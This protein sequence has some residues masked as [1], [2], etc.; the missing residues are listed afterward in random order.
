[1]ISFFQTFN[2]YILSSHFPVNL[3]ICI[4]IDSIHIMESTSR[5]Q[6]GQ[7]LL[8]RKP[9]LDKLLDSRLQKLDKSVTKASHSAQHKVLLSLATY[10]H[11]RLIT[12]NKLDTSIRIFASDGVRAAKKSNESRRS[13]HRSSSA[14]PKKVSARREPPVLEDV[15]NEDRKSSLDS[16][17]SLHSGTNNKADFV[18]FSESEISFPRRTR[19]LSV[20]LL[21]N[22]IATARRR[23]SA[24]EVI[25]TPAKLQQLPELATGPNLSNESHE[26]DHL[27]PSY[28]VTT[29]FFENDQGSANANDTAR[30]TQDSKAKPTSVSKTGSSSIGTT[31]RLPRLRTESTASMGKYTDLYYVSS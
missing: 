21:A 8:Y 4:T 3:S 22:P 5:S 15:D 12:E 2:I 30:N 26:V 25:I 6:L 27:S 17:T 11:A 1:M 29:E 10:S 9:A 18:R 23:Q 24:P 7:F 31:S 28:S 13:R 16:D 19:A 20:D 14:R